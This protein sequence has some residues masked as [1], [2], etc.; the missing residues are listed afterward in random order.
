M[1]SGL[2][3]SQFA[4]VISRDRG[5]LNDHES[6]IHASSPSHTLTNSRS[7][8]RTYSTSLLS[9]SF[10]FPAGSSQSVEVV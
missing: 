10:S 2:S 4:S 7:V 3:L 1:T 5:F 9:C 6:V 8:I